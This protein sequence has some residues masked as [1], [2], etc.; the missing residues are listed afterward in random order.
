MMNVLLTWVI[1]SH[2]FF[3]GNVRLVKG[4]IP[5]E[6]LLEVF[7]NNAWGTVHLYSWGDEANGIAK[8]VC[9]QL[10]YAG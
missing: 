3:I 6:G 8:V 1:N 5:S 4:K 9:R 7:H 2:Y 10:G